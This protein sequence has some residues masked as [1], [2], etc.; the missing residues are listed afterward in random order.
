NWGEGGF[1]SGSCRAVIEAVW[2]SSAQTA[3]VAVQDMCGFGSDARMNRP[4]TSEDNW[5]FRITQ[6]ALDGI[7]ENYF[8][9]INY[10]YRR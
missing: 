9:E 5:S 7:D 3:V 1:Y 2:R 10:V 8:R 6:G 4:G